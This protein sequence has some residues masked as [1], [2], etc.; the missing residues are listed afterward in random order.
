M[1][2]AAPAFTRLPRSMNR[3]KYHEGAPADPH[4]CASSRRRQQVPRFG[5]LGFG[6]KALRPSMRP[7]GRR[8][9]RGGGAGGEEVGDAWLGE[10]GVQLGGVGGGLVR[11]GADEPA[12]DGGERVRSGGVGRRA[13]GSWWAGLWRAV[14][15]EAGHQA[16]EAARRCG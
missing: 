15:G 12:M 5:R 7:S 6:A 9:R 8:M 3:C 13:V 11:Q 16:L 1:A 14:G 4:L 2:R 10:Q